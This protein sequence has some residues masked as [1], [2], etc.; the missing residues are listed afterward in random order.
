MF[1]VDLK[2]VSVD[3]NVVLGGQ[4]EANPTPHRPEAH[5]LQVQIYLELTKY[6]I[7]A[8][9]SAR[10]APLLPVHCL[11]GVA[12]G[13]AESVSFGL[14]NDN[15]LATPQ[16]CAVLLHP[17]SSCILFWDRLPKI[18]GPGWDHQSL[19]FQQ[20]MTRTGMRRCMHHFPHHSSTLVFPKGSLLC[21]IPQHHADPVTGA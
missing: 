5:R 13:A 2:C 15:I 16:Q 7:A 10:H 12:V 18:R 19:E 21:T 17:Q 9:F 11:A 4:V 14:L 6:V 1:L 3:D 20:A 8:S